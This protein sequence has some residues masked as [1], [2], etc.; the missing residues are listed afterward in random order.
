VI[1]LRKA[2][3]YSVTLIYPLNDMFAY[4]DACEITLIEIHFIYLGNKE[5]Y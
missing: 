4:A 2:F 1:E 3:G 5:L